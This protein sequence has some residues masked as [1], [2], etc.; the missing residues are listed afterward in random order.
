MS[1]KKV[2]DPIPQE[3]RASIMALLPRIVAQIEGGDPVLGLQLAKMALDVTREVITQD[4]IESQYRRERK[5]D[6]E[7]VSSAE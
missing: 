1:E 7:E 4:W 5:W 2:Y 6:D 3:V